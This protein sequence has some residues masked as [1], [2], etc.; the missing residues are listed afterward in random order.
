MKKKREESKTQVQAHLAYA[1]TAT[2]ID[3]GAS[4]HMFK[5]I[6]VFEED[7]QPLQIVITC[8]NLENI[9]STHIRTINIELQDESVLQLRDTLHILEIKHN[10]MLV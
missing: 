6:Q 9:Q 5:N 4:Q 10:L 7:I 2:I 8:V 3:S 1:G